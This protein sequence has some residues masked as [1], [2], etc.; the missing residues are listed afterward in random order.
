MLLN[1]FPTHLG[2]AMRESL[3]L[4]EGISATKVV[5]SIDNLHV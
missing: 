4:H 3:T 1:I 5:L 2:L